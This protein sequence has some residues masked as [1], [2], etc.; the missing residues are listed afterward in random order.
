[1]DARKK[2]KAK[3]ARWKHEKEKEITRRVRVG[4]NRSDVK[5][6]LKS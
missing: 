5:S 1:M 6:E 2:K 3:E 4:E